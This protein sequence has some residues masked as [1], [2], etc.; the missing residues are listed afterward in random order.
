MTDWKDAMTHPLTHAAMRRLN[1][2]NKAMRYQIFF[3]HPDGTEDSFTVSGETIEEIKQ[4]AQEGLDYRCIRSPQL[5]ERV[6]SSKIIGA[7]T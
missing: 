3:E 1:G 5:L 6:W 7:G 2:A 4:K